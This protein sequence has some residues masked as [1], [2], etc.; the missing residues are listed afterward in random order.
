MK[1]ISREL[2]LVIICLG[3]LVVFALFYAKNYTKKET[4]SSNKE[5]VVVSQEKLVNQLAA[6]SMDIYQSKTYDKCVEQG[7]YSC[8]IS[9]DSLEQNYGKDISLFKGAGA[10]CASSISGLSFYLDD[11][12]KPFSIILG[13]CK[14]NNSENT[15][16]E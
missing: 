14:Y 4:I 6:W 15:K 7:D 13:G 12:S 16:K 1:K 10:E 9:L 8:F 5:P 11:P 2:L 3:F